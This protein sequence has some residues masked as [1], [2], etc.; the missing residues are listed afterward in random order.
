MI[1]LSKGRSKM[2]NSR[3]L[4]L[5]EINEVPWKIID[6]YLSLGEYP[7]LE[8][9]FRLSQNFTT[10]TVDEGELSPWITWP[11]LHRGMP[12]TEHQVR[13][14]GQNPDTFRGKAIWEE[15]RERGLP[16]GICGSLQSWPPQDPGPGGFYIPDTFANDSRCIPEWVEPFQRVNLHFTK[17][18]G[19]VRSS[20]LPISAQNFAAFLTFA[21]RGI[22]TKTKLRIAEQLVMEKIDHSRIG[23]RPIFQAAMQWDVFRRLY[24]ADQPPAFASFFTNHLASA[25]HRYWHFVFPED[26]KKSPGESR[27]GSADTML[28]A[29]KVLN[30]ILGDVLSFQKKNPE[31]VIAFASSM[32]QEAIIWEKFEGCSAMVH[33]IG[34]LVSALCENFAESPLHRSLAMVPQVTVAMPDSKQRTLFQKNLENTRTA[35]GEPLFFAEEKLDQLS[36][37]IRTPSRAD[38]AAGGFDLVASGARRRISWAEAGIKIAEADPGTAYHV[39]EG[40]LAVLSKDSRPSNDRSEMAA[41]AVKPFLLDLCQL[42]KQITS[43]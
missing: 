6:H 37:S 36:I 29:M 9:F 3:P 25:M 15:F 2:H 35:S 5:L 27:E 12:A 28:F 26:F 32:G 40:V 39:P 21:L 17:E 43:M 1:L 10:R 8:K 19:R 20:S 4:I 38:I 30:E 41:T 23:R 33:D 22:S 42:G 14:L 13:F 31:I 11:T 18:N 7:H 16:I 34:K 24:R